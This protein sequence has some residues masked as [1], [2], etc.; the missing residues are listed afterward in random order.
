MENYTVRE[1]KA[2]KKTIYRGKGHM[3]RF[4]AEIKPSREYSGMWDVWCCMD[5]DGNTMVGGRGL[6]A[7]RPLA[8]KTAMLW[9]TQQDELTT[10]IISQ[11]AA[12]GFGGGGENVVQ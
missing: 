9:V 2:E 6:G 11:I 4:W 12:S 10:D 5:Y 7:K 8:D 3:R 1:I